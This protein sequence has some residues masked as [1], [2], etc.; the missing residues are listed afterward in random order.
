MSVDRC[1]SGDGGSVVLV[2]PDRGGLGVVPGAL[3]VGAGH[4]VLLTPRR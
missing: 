4:R 3:R 1:L 2:G